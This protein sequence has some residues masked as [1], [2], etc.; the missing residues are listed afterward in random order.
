[1][2]NNQKERFSAAKDRILKKY[3]NKQIPPDIEDKYYYR[4]NH[5]FHREGEFAA[6][7]WQLFQSHSSVLIRLDNDDLFPLMIEVAGYDPRKLSVK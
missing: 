3:N 7:M 2:T 6:V 1:M 4:L 5:A